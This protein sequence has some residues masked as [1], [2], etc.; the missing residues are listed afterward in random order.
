MYQKLTMLHLMVLL[1]QPYV[2]M[3]LV[4]SILVHVHL[5]IVSFVLMFDSFSYHPNQSNLY[6]TI[7]LHDFYHNI[8]KICYIHMSTLQFFWDHRVV[9]L[10]LYYLLNNHNCLH[11]ILSTWILELGIIIFWSLNIYI[12]TSKN[13]HIN[14]TVLISDSWI[15]IVLFPFSKCEYPRGHFLVPILNFGF[16]LSYSKFIS[17]NSALALE[18]F[19]LSLS[20]FVFSCWCLF[21][22]FILAVFAVKGVLFQV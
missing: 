10:N 13:R 20:C 19:V 9:T 11:S 8:C 18:H 7:Q 6:L 21:A 22:R 4:N 14:W 15:N 12:H 1:D 2:L 3:I 16:S 17:F 5:H